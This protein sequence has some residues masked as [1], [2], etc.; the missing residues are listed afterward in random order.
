MSQPS[1]PN[2]NSAPQQN[3][4]PLVLS[5]LTHLFLVLILLLF[6]FSA[7][8]PGPE[9]DI[10]RAGIVLAVA[11][12]QKET[13]Y[14]TDEDLSQESQADSSSE[15]IDPAASPPPALAT[16]S[17]TPDRPDLPGVETFEPSEFDANQMANVPVESANNSQYELSEQDLKLIRADQ[18][19]VQSRK[20]VGNPATLNVFGSGNLTGRSFVFVLDRSNSMGRGG[21]GVIQAAKS[22]LTAAINQLEAHHKFQIVGYHERTVTVSKRKLLLAT[23]ENKKLVPGFIDNLAAFGAT[24]HEAGMVSALAFKPDVVVLMTDGGYPELNESQLKIMKQVAGRRC[25]I[26]CLQF[27]MGKLQQQINFMTKL[28]SQNQGSFNYIDVTEWKNN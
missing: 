7:V 10:R 13:E 3:W 15:T 28:S 19:L 23:D 26:H 11:N 18:R 22:Q 12:E 27:G 9:G 4:R 1:T 8:R 20:P 6:G 2:P 5:L 16:P 21:L 17:V 14:L 25:S 24:N